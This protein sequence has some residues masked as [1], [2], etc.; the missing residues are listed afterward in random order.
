MGFSSVDDVT[1]FS[2]PGRTLFGLGGGGLYTAIPVTSNAE[3]RVEGSFLHVGADGESVTVTT[4][5]GYGTALLSG[6]E[7]SSAY[8]L[9][10][11]N[12]LSADGETDYSV[13]AD[14]GYRVVG[15]GSFVFRLEG[16][17]QHY[18]DANETAISLLVGI[19]AGIG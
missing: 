5:G 6:R 3:V 16:R 15:S 11:A 2:I 9:G 8:V 4:I 19:G 10:G 14:L 13:G 12:F 18:F 1:V 17:F 7:R